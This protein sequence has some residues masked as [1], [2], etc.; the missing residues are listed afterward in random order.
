MERGK[1][2]QGRWIP[3]RSVTDFFARSIQHGLERS[4]DR[5]SADWCDRESDFNRENGVQPLSAGR[6][7]NGGFCGRF[8][9]PQTPSLDIVVT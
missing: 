8:G 7:L 1:R 9:S 4:C 6:G 2:L 5:G 3:I